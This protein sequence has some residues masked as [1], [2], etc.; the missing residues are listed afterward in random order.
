[1]TIT[2]NVVSNTLTY[3][4]IVALATMLL[5]GQ[6]DKAGRPAIDHAFRVVD[7]LPKSAT[8]GEAQVALLHDVLED[9]T[10]TEA[11]LRA[12][13][14]SE[15]VLTEVV[16]LTRLQS[17]T[18]AAYID[19]VAKRPVA[20]MVKLADI[21]DHLGLVVGFQLPE[22]LRERYTRARDVLRAAK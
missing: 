12:L 17:E 3:Q 19:R 4:Q 10:A 9:T 11:D 15:W 21:A 5:R 13:G 6:V 16:A 18:Y 1:M 20:R 14:V 22:S 2:S 8:Y 7:R